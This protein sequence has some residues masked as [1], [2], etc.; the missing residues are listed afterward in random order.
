MDTYYNFSHHVSLSFTFCPAQGYPLRF[1]APIQVYALPI[2]FQEI[3]QQ[4]L[5]LL[6]MLLVL[7]LRPPLNII[8]PQHQPF[9]S[10][11]S[12]KNTEPTMI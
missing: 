7:Q 5:T 11:D 6:Y 4:S 9:I 12:S 8:N 2:R 1:L 10:P 3:F